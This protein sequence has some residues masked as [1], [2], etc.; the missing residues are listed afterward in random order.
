MKKLLVLL[1]ALWMICPAM[2]EESALYLLTNGAGTPAGTAALCLDASTLLAP[3]C[4][5]DDQ[6]LQATGA[7]GTFRVTGARPMGNDLALLT[8]DAPSPAAPV[9]INL[10]GTPARAL[11]H[12]EKGQACTSGLDYRSVV[13]FG[14][15]FA[16]IFT[17]Q[18]AMLPGG[19]LVD[20]SGALCGMVTRAYGEG[21]HRYVAAVGN[22][23]AGVQQNAGWVTD[24]A[25]TPGPGELLVD[26]SACQ[27]S[28][29]EKDCVYTVFVQD[30][31]NPFF[32]YYVVEEGTQTRMQLPPGRSYLVWLQ[33][34]HGEPRPDVPMAADCA[35]P[36][37]LPDPAAFD[38]YAFRNAMIHLSAVPAREAEQAE[39]TCLP[40][41]ES[42]TLSALTDPDTAIFL[43]VRSTYQVE[44]TQSAMLV[45]TLETPEGC[46]FAL[47][48]T[49][50]FEPSLQQQDDWNVNITELLDSCISYCGQLSP[51]EYTLSFYLD[52]SL[53]G[54]I[55]FELE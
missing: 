47:E 43:Q 17:V 14:N 29:Q 50:G 36:V 26:W 7:G 33:H 31:G 44:E 21:I 41:M 25:A 45:A 20:G 34:A 52:G 16:L 8:L 1:L 39:N 15:D 38:L 32:S 23:L 48:G 53:G 11:G 54:A 42:I 24:F 35:V 19:L 55:G 10:T 27:P 30:K 13:P 40:P 4:L 46:C 2:A 49:F 9:D 22:M 51:G 28:C 37:R 6:G 18:Q 3:A 5:A 12:D